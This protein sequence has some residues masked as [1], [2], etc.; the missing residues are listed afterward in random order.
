ML[1]NE[2]FAFFIMNEDVKKKRPRQW[3]HIS[4]SSVTL[5]T[6]LDKC[7][8]LTFHASAAHVHLYSDQWTVCP[9]V[10]DEASALQKSL[11]VGQQNLVT[12]LVVQNRI[13]IICLKLRADSTEH[14]RS[15]EKQLICWSDHRVAAE[16]LYTTQLEHSF[17]TFP[18]FTLCPFHPSSL[19]FFLLNKTS[20][21]VR[22]CKTRKK[23]SS[24]LNQ[25]IVLRRC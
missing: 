10:W 19:C 15:C 13:S 1:I 6:P 20:S 24:C 2:T 3:S 14:V 21:I 5:N 4:T 16:N 22:T 11:R 17:S 9:H 8:S 23:L 12:K 18:L 25:E 7:L